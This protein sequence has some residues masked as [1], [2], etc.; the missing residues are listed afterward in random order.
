M[1]VKMVPYDHTSLF[2]PCS[3]SDA[4]MRETVEMVRMTAP[5]PPRMTLTTTRCATDCDVQSRRAAAVGKPTGIGLE[6][7]SPEVPVHVAHP[8]KST[9]AAG[10]S[11]VWHRRPHGCS[12]GPRIEQALRA[13]GGAVRQREPNRVRRLLT[14]D[15]VSLRQR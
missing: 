4:C 5:V 8:T 6:R 11:Q 7:Y 15:T 1:G 13:L 3:L 2:P 9:Q 10:A 12:L 14:T